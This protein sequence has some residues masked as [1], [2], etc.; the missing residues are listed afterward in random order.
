MKKVC[1]TQAKSRLVWAT[2][3]FGLPER[4][5]HFEIATRRGCI[6]RSHDPFNVAAQNG[7]LL[8]ADYH[9]RDFP[10]LQVL[11]VA[12]VL[13]R[14]EQN[15]ETF[16]LGCR[17]QLAVNEAIPSAFYS[18]NNSVA[19]EGISKRSGSA[20]IEEYSH[21]PLRWAAGQGARQGSAQQIR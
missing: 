12:D 4:N 8:I 10:A 17:D 2:P 18:F 15:F 13:V 7:P 5:F 9:K 1:P 21:R 14:R 3:P 11:L 6:H 19:F 16:R 20:V